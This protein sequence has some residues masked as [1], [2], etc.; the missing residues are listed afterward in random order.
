MIMGILFIIYDS[1]WILGEKWWGGIQFQFNFGF[2]TFD[3]D[4]GFGFRTK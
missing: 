1:R 2:E 3:L 4:L